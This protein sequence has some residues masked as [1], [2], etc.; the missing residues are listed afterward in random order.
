M[1]LF[2]LL[3]ITPGSDYVGIMAKQN[4]EAIVRLTDQKKTELLAIPVTADQRLAW[5][6]PNPYSPV[7]ACIFPQKVTIFDVRRRSE[8]RVFPVP[9]GAVGGIRWK[10]NNTLVFSKVDWTRENTIYIYEWKPSI[11]AKPS[12]IQVVTDRFQESAAIGGMKLEAANLPLPQSA[13]KLGHDWDLRMQGTLP[14]ALRRMASSDLQFA[15]NA[16]THQLEFFRRGQEAWKVILPTTAARFAM[17]RRSGKEVSATF[18]GNPNNELWTRAFGNRSQLTDAS[19]DGRSSESYTTYFIDRTG[20]IEQVASIG[21]AV[22][23]DWK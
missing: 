5:F 3:L 9:D 6:E 13:S 23:V 18:V 17:L 19:P 1:I 4:G 12:L 21:Y 14:V 22:R 15:V 7:I 20:R 11:E 8:T 16:S 2:G 10:S